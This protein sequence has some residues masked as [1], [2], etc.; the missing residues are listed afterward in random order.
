MSITAFSGPVV[1]FG[2]APLGSANDYNADRGPSL[3]DQG[4]GL[5]DPR[6]P[7][8]YLPGQRAGQPTYGFLG[9][10]GI[11]TISAVPATLA[12]ANIAASQTPVA[13][14]PLTLVSATG[15]GI[16][17]AQTISRSDTNVLVTGLLAID[18]PS[19][20]KAFGQGPLGT[21]GSVYLWDPT[22]LIA[23][24]VRVV[25]AGNDSTATFVVRGFDI[26]WYPMVETITGANAGTATGKKAFKYI[27]SIT[28]AGTLSGSAV[29][30]GT[31]DVIGLPLR[32]DYF[33]EFEANVSSAWI[34]A[35]TGYVAPD[36]TS[37]ATATT[38]DVRGTY[39]LQTASNGTVRVML[40]SSPSVNNI[41]SATGLFGV[42][43]FTNF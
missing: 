23:R 43:Q 15:A 1:A 29:T 10:T 38:G 7:F 5:M 19:A 9:V 35:N 21:G 3:F 14:T 24:A 17:V 36:A 16:T 37:P 13:A 18:G 39:L 12:V 31:T 28:P 25:S 22:T 20:G 32:A 2:G 33:G 11:A 42:S 40:Y 8:S 27:S 34:T 41:S 30:V 6:N 26:Y 4:A